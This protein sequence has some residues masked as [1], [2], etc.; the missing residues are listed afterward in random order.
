MVNAFWFLVFTSGA[1]KTIFI[2]LQGTKCRHCFQIRP[3]TFCSSLHENHWRQVRYLYYF[4]GSCNRREKFLSTRSWS[5]LCPVGWGGRIYRLLLYREVRPPLNECP[6]YDTKQSDGEFPEV[7]EL[8]GMRSTPSLYLL[9]GP[10]GP[11][12]VA[13]EWALSMG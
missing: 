4:W 1:K 11:K 10:L 12:V 2:F 3:I 7:L 5:K 8:W 13:P 9:P 6:R